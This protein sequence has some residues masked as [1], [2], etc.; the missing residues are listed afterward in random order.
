M[1][2][3]E[4]AAETLGLHLDVVVRQSADLHLPARRAD[5]I[6]SERELSA[7]IRCFN[8]YALGIQRHRPTKRV[9]HVPA[10]KREPRI[11][12]TGIRRDS[13]HYLE[14]TKHVFSERF[15]PGSSP[16]QSTDEGATVV[17]GGTRV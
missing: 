11:L 14:P 5:R 9:S 16:D 3:Q 15:V 1:K 8:V 12:S 7:G 2:P 10:T 6:V 4:L 17:E 13:S